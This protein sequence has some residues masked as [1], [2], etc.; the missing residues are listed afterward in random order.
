MDLR[1]IAIIQGLAQIGNKRYHLVIQ[2]SN[3]PFDPADWTGIKRCW[4]KLVFE[5]AW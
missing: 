3:V 1:K 4:Y 5:V 2:P